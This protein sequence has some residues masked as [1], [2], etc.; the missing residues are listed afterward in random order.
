MTDS[1]REGKGAAG[2]ARAGQGGERARVDSYIIG[3]ELTLPTD[4]YYG[5]RRKYGSGRGVA[6]MESVV[7]F[8]NR[9]RVAATVWAISRYGPVRGYGSLE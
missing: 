9:E 8:R 3:T 6:K 7:W 2:Q 1:R 4:W 5:D